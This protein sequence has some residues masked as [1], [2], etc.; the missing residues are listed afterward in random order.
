MC[1]NWRI[2]LSHVKAWQ[3]HGD[4]CIGLYRKEGIFEG[5][6][7][8]YS[9]SNVPT[10]SRTL[11]PV[12]VCWNIFVGINVC[13]D[14]RLLHILSVLGHLLFLFIFTAERWRGEHIT[15]S[16][17]SYRILLLFVKHITLGRLFI[18]IAYMVNIIHATKCR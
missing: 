8:T 7:Y 5:R 12:V 11:I 14:V 10:T 2:L 9:V 17:D 16:S 13:C 6:L 4:S 3:M 1:P 15:V 18:L